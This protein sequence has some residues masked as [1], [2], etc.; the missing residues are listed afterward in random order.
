MARAV[1]GLAFI[2]FAAF[3]PTDPLVLGASAGPPGLWD[4]RNWR[5][6]HH[7][8]SGKLA[9]TEWVLSEEAVESWTELVT[10]QF[11]A[12]HPSPQKAVR[13]LQQSME[14]HCPNVV[15][16]ILQRDAQSV[17][18]EWRIK[19]CGSR[20]D[21]SEIARFVM[22]DE[23]T[24]R[25]AYSAK[26][27]QLSDHTRSRWI[28]LL[29]Q[30]RPSDLKR[31]RRESVILAQA[32]VDESKVPKE[33]DPELS[34][35]GVVFDLHEIQRHKQHGTTVIIYKFQ[36]AGLPADKKYIVW[37]I[38]SGTSK[39][40]A[41]L[42]AEVGR[43]G[44]VVYDFQGD[45]G[46]L[47]KLK[48]K[49]YSY[50]KGQPLRFALVSTDGTVYAFAKKVPFPIQARDGSCRISVEIATREAARLLLSGFPV[51]EPI[52]V[53][54]RFGKETTEESFVVQ[55]SS[56]RDGLQKEILLRPRRKSGR[57]TIDVKA[58]S[59]KVSAKYQWGS[60]AKFQ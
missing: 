29:T 42:N 6:G 27:T 17:L 56:R 40:V 2:F 21:H 52:Q 13:R 22:T 39:P 41:M 26:A 1:I 7:A 35:S 38:L 44:E 48:F 4:G 33:F 49:I 3:A 25:I 18:Y 37:N 9:I 45:R 60:K 50:V 36:V 20:P 11:F 59:C 8:D 24:Y 32:P 12:S 43:S 16:N 53:I 30:V 34:T 19:D 47:E 10:L 57:A 14:R 23:G 15:W 5:I 55:R 28:K 58:L 46:T 51:G 31:L 54:T